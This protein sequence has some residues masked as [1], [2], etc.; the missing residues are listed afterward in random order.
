MSKEINT[1]E[2]EPAM[3]IKIEGSFVNV[4]KIKRIWKED[5]KNQFG[6]PNGEYCLHV[7]MEN[8]YKGL[9]T[10]YRV[11]SERDEELEKV[12]EQLRRAKRLC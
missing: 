9:H 12:E 8:E 11:R 7:D 6:K 4:N 10:T 2:Q 3:F 5:K 1:E